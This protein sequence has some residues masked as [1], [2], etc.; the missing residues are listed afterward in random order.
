MSDV[1][2]GPPPKIWARH[3]A[4]GQGWQDGTWTSEPDDDRGV[5]YVPVERFHALQK[6]ALLGRQLALDCIDYAG[7]C[8]PSEEMDIERFREI[9]AALAEA[10]GKTPAEG[11]DAQST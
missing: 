11:D 4:S 1:P 2:N 5:Q 8:T 6:V 7:Q 10:D 9:E 3:S